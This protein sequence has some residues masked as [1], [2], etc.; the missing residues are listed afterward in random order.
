[1][2]RKSVFGVGWGIAA[3]LMALL[4]TAFLL[5]PAFPFVPLTVGANDV[6]GYYTYICNDKFVDGYYANTRY[7]QIIK[8]D[9]AI[10]GD[11]VLPSM[12]GGYPVEDRPGGVYRLYANHERYASG[13]NAEH[14]RAR[15]HELYGYGAHY[16]SGECVSI[17]Y[18]CIFR[19][20][21]FA[22]HNDFRRRRVYPCGYVFGLCEPDGNQRRQ[23]QFGIS[24]RRR[25]F[26]FE[27]YGNA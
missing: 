19:L 2:K 4:L 22:E 10:S 25:R 3:R 26:I 23:E 5:G 15:V 8:C 14:W 11:V 9:P 16:D 1:M 13:D 20:H 12:L 18:V 7:A 24:K 21:Q 17:W 27:G 6:E